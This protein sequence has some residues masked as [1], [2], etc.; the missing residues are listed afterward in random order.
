[1]ISR[2]ILLCIILVVIS[3]ML[4][5]CGSD[6]TNTT[7][8]T[9]PSTVTVTESDA[10]GSVELST[11][12]ILVVELKGNL[13]TG[14]QW[15]QVGDDPAILRQAGEPEFT[16]DSSAIGSPGKVSLRFEAA[17]SGQM[18]LNLAYQRSFEPQAPAEQT[19]EMD[20]TVK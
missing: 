4:V 2:K 16:P 19:F 18:L 17:G 12:D 20:V 1:M 13:S 11:G 9:T 14:Y 7:T 6:G 10:G 5:S 3:V 8:V 15:Q